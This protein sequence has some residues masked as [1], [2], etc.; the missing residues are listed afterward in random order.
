MLET[1]H[2]LESAQATIARD[3]L[4]GRI[5]RNT[6]V[7]LTRKYQLVSLERAR[8]SV[9][10]LDE[11]RSYAIIYG[12]ADDLVRAHVE[13]AGTDTKSRWAALERVISEPTL[14]DDLMLH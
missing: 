1:L 11:Y 7:E 6:A 3:Y 12:I 4:E 8:R 9:A 5:D 10:F 2:A 13:R 14:P